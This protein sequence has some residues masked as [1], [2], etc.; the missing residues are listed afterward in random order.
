[1]P[2][3]GAAAAGKRHPHALE[4]R[5]A[6]GLAPA[7]RDGL[8]ASRAEVPTDALDLGERDDDDHRVVDLCL[9]RGA[10]RDERVDAPDPSCTG[11]DERHEHEEVD[12][13]GTRVPRGVVKA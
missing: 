9:E 6:V 4:V 3:V 1:M 12:E 8:A 13:G 2:A 7:V 5:A 11:D 10:S